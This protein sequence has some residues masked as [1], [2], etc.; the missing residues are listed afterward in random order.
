MRSVPSLKALLL[1]GGLL[2][3][4]A[5]AWAMGDVVLSPTS[6]YPAYTPTVLNYAASRGGMPTEILGNPFQVPEEELA[7]AVTRMMTGSHFGPPVRFLTETPED[8]ASPYRVVL[9]FDSKPHHTTLKLCG[10]DARS[11]VRQS[12][13]VLRVHAA[14]CA[15]DKP[16]TSVSGRVSGASGPG[17]ARFRKLIGQITINL[18]PR[19]NPD[20]ES[21]HFFNPG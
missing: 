11:L 2:A 20:H 4:A 7:R 18:F 5:P 13:G 3:G 1:A 17:D 21:D 19:R 16:L 14:L 9:L 15:N 10:E 12:N 8:F 6:F